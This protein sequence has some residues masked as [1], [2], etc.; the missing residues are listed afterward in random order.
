VNRKIEAFEHNEPA[1]EIDDLQVGDGVSM[2]IYTDA[3]AYTIIKRTAKTITLQ[4]DNATLINGD[5]LHF[6]IGGFA[7]HCSNQH[8][9]KYDYSPNP[10]GAIVKISRREWVDGAG[11]KRVKWK[12]S[13]SD[14][15]SPGNAARPGRR[16]F[17]DY[18]F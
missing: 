6:H 5:K 18:N 13:G 11:C 8:E 2:T 12:R 3:H 16:K 14:T 10:N 9:Q 15:R 7:A 4:E 17:H 1:L